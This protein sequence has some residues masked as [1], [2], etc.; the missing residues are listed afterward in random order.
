MDIGIGIAAGL[1]L[2]VIG[3]FIGR[4][5]ARAQGLA[6]GRVEADARLKA[7]AEALS[8]GRL[9]DGATADS[10]E[11]Q[12][13]AALE[14]GWSPRETERMAAL[15]EAVT[16]VSGFL[17]SEVRE[18][19]SGVG[20]DA[21]A[22]E[23]RHRIDQA[24]GALADLDFFLA[25]PPK[26]RDARDV[27]PLVRQVSREFASDQNVGLRLQLEG[28]P[29]RASVNASVLMDAL[30]LILHNAGRFGGGS[31]IDV[32]VVSK[33]GRALV[34]VRDRGDGFSEEAFRRAFDPFYST[35]SDGL[36]LGLPHARTLVE[37]L[38]G[39]IELRNVPDGGAEVEISFPLV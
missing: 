24:V 10:A 38:G 6:A 9:P 2:A 26:D 23:L 27:V 14:S 18:P 19:L 7:A 16:R 3:F 17:A 39:R 29:V 12:L 15:R 30:Y 34:S 8:R 36:G 1:V 11:A 33:D 5:G 21:T 4:S 35:T 31:T 20:E 13:N 28:R 25:P 37:G 32:T 22:E